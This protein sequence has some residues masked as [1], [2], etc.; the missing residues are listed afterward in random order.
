MNQ[1]MTHQ[2]DLKAVASLTKREFEVLTHLGMGLTHREIA[3]E[4][5]ITV[6]TVNWHMAHIIEKT[7]VSGRVKL[8]RIAIR[9]GL[10][11]L[12]G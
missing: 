5:G 1:A 7:G 10:S 6:K 4:L 12:W 3:E 2:K 8:A 9:V 11:P